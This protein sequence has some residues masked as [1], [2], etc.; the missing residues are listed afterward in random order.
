MHQKKGLLSVILSILIITQAVPV[1]TS[2][3]TGDEKN[4]DDPIAASVLGEK[5]NPG[6][7]SRK[8]DP[9]VKPT[10][11]QLAAA[12]GL[13]KTSG[14]GLKVNWNTMLGTPSMIMTSKGYLTKP[15][16]GDAETIAREWM[17][18]YAAL[19]GLAA[20][21]IDQLKVSRDYAITGTGL[22]PVT[23]QQ[24][25][26]GLKSVYGGRI[27][28]AV[29]KDGKILSVTGNSR[30]S[31]KLYD[32]Y[33]LSAVD[34]LTKVSSSLAPDLKPTFNQKNEEKG[35]E[36]FSAGD[37]LPTVQ[38][39]KKAVFLTNDKVIPAYRVLFVKDLNHAYE[40]VINGV[41]GEKLFQRSLVQNLESEG[42]VFENYPGAPKGG[43]QIVRSFAGDPN[44]SPN[45]WVSP[46]KDIG[47]TTTGN[48]ANTYAN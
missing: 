28:V 45:G 25:F 27:I 39:V 2:F 33:K 7:D 23:F 8:D 43:S 10:K 9:F 41:T 19:F 21:D 18:N 47:V 31:G 32:D 6:F 26:N 48:N 20:A 44:A 46:L 1:K 14:S 36:V 40:V 22:H 3:A 35:W 12:N 5:R 13:I 37:K 30:R 42:F 4:S 34:A 38:R 11:E 29:S 17:E 16:E 24:T 15:A